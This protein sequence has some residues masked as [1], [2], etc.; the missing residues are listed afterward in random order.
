MNLEYGF[1]EIQEMNDFE[2]LYK[3]Y[4]GIIKKYIEQGYDRKNIIID[5][6]SGTKPMSVALV[7]AALATDVS[8][9]SYTY[10]IRGGG[11]RV[12]SGKERVITLSTTL[13]DTEKRLNQAKIFFNKNLFEASE[14]FL[15]HYKDISH[16]NFEWEIKFITKLSQA[17]NFWDKFEFNKSFEILNELKKNEEMLKI[18]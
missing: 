14:E 9:I 7:T 18:A 11:G 12:K 13:F 5:Y 1:E 2:I 15:S 16:P 3:E 8:Y 10:G 4:L 17:L 6:T